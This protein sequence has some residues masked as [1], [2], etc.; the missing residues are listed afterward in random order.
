MKFKVTEVWEHLN[1]SVLSDYRY[2]FLRGSSRSSKTISAIQYVILEC[3]KTP[4]LSV[5]IARATQVSLRHTM[6]PDFK[7]IMESL[8]IWDDG[9][10]HKQDFI[11]TFP[12]QSVIRFIGLDDSTGKLKGFK[13]DIIIVDE[14][15]TVDKSS[16]IQLDIRCSK[17]IIALYNP[18]IPID[19]WGLEYENKENG[20]MLH[21]TWKMNPFLDD[22]TI[23]AI[24]E[25][26]D[27]D[28][29]MAKIYSEGLIVEPREKIFIQ[30]ETFSELPKNIKQKYYGIDFGFS[31]D[32]CAVVEVH[33][34]GKNLFV[35]QVLY[36]KGLTNDDLAFK[37]KDIGIDRNIDIVADSAEPKSIAEL[38]R[39][40]L[41]VRPVSKTS[42]L[43]GIQ[44]MKQFKLY[45]Q[46]DSVDLISEFSNYKYKKDKIGNVTNQTAGK[47]H[48]L[49][50]LKYV[51]LQFVDKPKS[52][53]TI[54]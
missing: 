42:I 21:S 5:T 24:K 40:G 23:Q 32:E 4:K 26:I 13:S 38:K 14:V 46:E 12:N 16:F 15:N 52:K 6:L 29:D 31:N 43:Y 25:L 1:N 53:I 41:N 19:W 8:G 36:E 22:R 37:L 10:L 48:L 47:D 45:L 18:E 9:V 49:D 2:I 35:K 39:Y 34:D 50:A 51:V 30:P 54:V 44:K 20:I 27:T 11:Y 7:D 33:V 17:Y 3:I 28:P